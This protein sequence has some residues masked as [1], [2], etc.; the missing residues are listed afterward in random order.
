MAE[1]LPFSISQAARAFHKN[2]AEYYS[3]VANVLRSSAGLIKILQIFEND[4]QRYKGTPRGTLSVLWHERY[5]D[6]GGNL[7]DALDG[8][9]P[10]D[11]LAIVR[12]AQNAGVD[13]LIVAFDD[14]GRIA[15]LSDKVRKET[16]GTLLAGILGITIAVLML[17][18]FPVFSVG[19]LRSAYD[20]LPLSWWGKSGKAFVAYAE[21]IKTY[22]ILV[23]VFVGILVAAINWSLPN[24]V[25][26]VR[27]WLDERIVLYRV[28]RD[29]KGAM[30]L[31]TMATLTRKR[32]GVMFTLK[33]SLEIFS[34]SAKTPWLKWRINQVIEGAD[35]SGAIGVD[36]FNTG[37]INKEMYFFLEDMQRAKGFAEGFEATGLYVESTVLESII[38]RMTVYR[39][40]MLISAVLVAVSMFAWQFRVIHEMKSAM[41]LYIASPH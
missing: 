1:K 20:F 11:E 41:S 2:R 18:A 9:L 33:Q 15:K 26:P 4:S 12:V 29:L 8:T 19:A 31:S 40:A 37:L 6:N 23:V 13:A 38:K 5:S 36:A 32:A 17:T 25:T 30:F 34:E 21:W 39:W 3:Y 7:A 16:L 35:A 10:E 22:I 24:L 14:I 28:I 27:E